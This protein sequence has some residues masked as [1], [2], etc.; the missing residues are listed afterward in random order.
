MGI[1][2]GLSISLP[3]GA[4]PSICLVAIAGITGGVGWVGLVTLIST[5]S[6]AGQGTTMSLNAAMFQIG[7]ALGGLFGGLLLAVGGYATLGLGLMAFAFLA[8]SLVWRLPPMAILARYRRR[9]RPS[10]DVSPLLRERR[11][12]KA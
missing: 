6:P 2:L 10:I 5:S 9:Q 1:F 12:Q 11:C 8:A 4:I 3:A 7:S